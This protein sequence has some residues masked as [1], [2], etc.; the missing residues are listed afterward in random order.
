VASAILHCAQRNYQ[1]NAFFS[2]Y[3][4]GY[5]IDI[6]RLAVSKLMTSRQPSRTSLSAVCGR[7]RVGKKNLHFAALVGAAMCSAFLRGSVS[8]GA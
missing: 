3:C 1:I 4:R 6:A 8:V 2:N 5:L 7:L